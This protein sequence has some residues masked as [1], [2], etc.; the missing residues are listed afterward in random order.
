MNAGPSFA[1]TCRALALG[2]VLV[3]LVAG[4]DRSEDADR[5]TAPP[6]STPPAAATVESAAPV[7]QDGLAALGDAVD[8]AES[9]AA[10]TEQDLAADPG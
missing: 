8:A 4:C 2:T 6:A 1:G 7:P 10:Q 5:V 9:A 3:A